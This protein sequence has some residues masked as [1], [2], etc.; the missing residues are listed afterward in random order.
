MMSITVKLYK[1]EFRPSDGDGRLPSRHS[2]GDYDSFFN[3]VMKAFA[4][5]S[6][7]NKNAILARNA[8][9]YLSISIN[10][11]VGEMKADLLSP[12]H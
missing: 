9:L 8:H 5:Q 3:P 11:M 6:R 12:T 4:V 7:W 1:M 2:R 10:K